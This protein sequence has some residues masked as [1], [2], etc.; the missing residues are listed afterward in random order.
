MSNFCKLSACTLAVFVTWSSTAQA[1]VP[2][3]PVAPPHTLWRF[4]G[5]PQGI[6][7]IRDVTVNRR[8]NRPGLERKPPMTRIADPANLASDN[9]AIKAAAEIKTAED[10]KK[11]KIKAIKYLSTIGCGCYDKDGKITEALLAAT[12]DCTPEVRMAAI[13]AIEAAASGEC[14]RS[15]GSTSCCNE[16]IGKRLSEIAYERDDNGCPL[17]PNADIRAAAKRALCK[18]CPNRVPAGLIEEDYSVEDLSEVDAVEADREPEEVPIGESGEADEDAIGESDNS[19][20]EATGDDEDVN[21]DVDVDVELELNQPADDDQALENQPS[22]GSLGNPVVAIPAAIRPELTFAEAI[23]AEAQRIAAENSVA[24][25]HGNEPITTEPN[26][27]LRI[28]GIAIKPVTIEPVSF[29]KSDPAELVVPNTE[30][31]NPPAAS[32]QARDFQPQSFKPVGGKI[33]AIDHT[34][35]ELL[36]RA[37]QLRHVNPNGTVDVFHRYLTGER[38]VGQL[39]VK[40]IGSKMVKAKVVDLPSIARMHVGDRVIL[41]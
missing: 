24:D 14:C 5:I 37:D 41:R 33:V 38:N 22:G 2:V 10:M 32:P 13:E 19:A 29:K 11:Q 12:D 4:I 39:K 1:Q 6:Q 31:L 25:D 15:C 7:K 34:S 27:V 18:C 28:G 20:D 17:E 21:V 8:G 36:V 26:R 30:P 3:V 23:T 40:Q 16:D 35:G 9:P